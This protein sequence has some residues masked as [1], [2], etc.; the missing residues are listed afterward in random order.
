MK[1]NRTVCVVVIVAATLVACM[2]ALASPKGHNLHVV[3]DRNGSALVLYGGDKDGSIPQCMVRSISE[4]AVGIRRIL[5]SVYLRDTDSI[6][7]GDNVVATGFGRTVEYYDD[8]TGDEDWIEI[9][10]TTQTGWMGNYPQSRSD[11]IH[12]SEVW[13]CRFEWLDF[14]HVPP[15]ADFEVSNNVV[16]WEGSDTSGNDWY[17]T[18]YY[19]GIFAMGRN[20][21][22][23]TQYSAGTH[24]FTA[25]GLVFVTAS[26]H[27]YANI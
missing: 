25:N 24:K 10:G 22:R 27:D 8:W 5:C 2:P 17:M 12:L 13:T 1:R 21:D 3:Y 20:P 7:Y 16:T 6:P 23:V 14:L 18:H 15:S 19:T 11:E 4:T 26:A 9:G